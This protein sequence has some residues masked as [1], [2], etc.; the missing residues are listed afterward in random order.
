MQ[1]VAAVHQRRQQLVEHA[2]ALFAL[3][4]LG[5]HVAGQRQGAGAGAGDGPGQG[6]QQQA[7]QH[8]DAE[9]QR[10]QPGR[11]LPS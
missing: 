9:G 7:R 5:G 10:R 3:A 1:W 4:V 2:E 11:R 6:G 8:A